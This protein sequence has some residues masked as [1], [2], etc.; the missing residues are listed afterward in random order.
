MSAESVQNEQLSSKRSSLLRIS[1]SL[2]FLGVALG[3]FG[4]HGLEKVI[5]DPD[6]LAVW[7]TAVFY[8]LL[9]AVMLYVIAV[10]GE[11]RR[12]AWNCL[13]LGIVV[14]SGSLYALVLSDIGW[15]G[16]ITPIGG[17]LFLV[18][19]AMLFARPAR[20]SGFHR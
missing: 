2:G 6:R 12:L 18:G 7:D 19:W 16:A 4:A 20:S 3:A 9:H 1:T 5:D 11:L 8:H 10:A 15:L 14:F 13:A 17:V